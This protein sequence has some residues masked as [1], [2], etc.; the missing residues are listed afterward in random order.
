[1]TTKNAFQTKIK[2][3]EWSVSSERLKCVLGT[4]RG[5]SAGRWFQGGD[6]HLIET[7]EQHERENCDLPDSYDGLIYQGLHQSSLC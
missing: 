1:M 6:A 3:F 4:G 7:D 5:E 2:S